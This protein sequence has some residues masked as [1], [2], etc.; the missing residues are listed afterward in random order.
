M[1]LD[2]FNTNDI[3]HSMKITFNSPVILVFTI[4]CVA[5]QAYAS[6]VNQN[7]SILF[8]VGNSIDLTNPIDYFT[9]ISHAMGHS[10]WEHLTGN[11][12]FILAIGPIIEEKYGSQKLVLML[13]I[14][15]FITGI[16]NVIFKSSYITGA[17]GIVFMLILLGSVTNIKKRQ[18]P[19]TFILIF[20]LYIG[21]EVLNTF[22]SDY[23]Q[24]SQF[25]H[26]VGG[27]CGS[28]FGFIS[29]NMNSK[30]ENDEEEII[31]DTNI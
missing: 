31:E 7:I 16:L 17:S 1:Y 26:I 21:K 11:F 9:L 30:D 29:I 4:I 6:F 24:T 22:D 25:G 15:A 20:L 23:H 10:G 12:M 19:L 27:I 5:V 2:C 3:L 18:I 8:A 14:T 13:F 28:I